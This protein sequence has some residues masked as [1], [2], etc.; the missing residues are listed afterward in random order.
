MQWLWWMDGG[1]AMVGC[2]V[3][4][5]WLVWSWV[6]R[7]TA[8]CVIVVGDVSWKGREDWFDPS[9][10]KTWRFGLLES[11]CATFLLGQR[12]LKAQSVL[13][14]EKRVKKIMMRVLAQNLRKVSTTL[15]FKRGLWNCCCL[16]VFKHGVP[17]GQ[18]SLM[19]NILLWKESTMRNNRTTAAKMNMKLICFNKQIDFF[20]MVVAHW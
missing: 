4:W 10:K 5:W 11:A 8:C 9:R 20:N 18:G 13:P 7:V 14:H 16:T 3:Y 12:S 1:L 17:H 2:L 19:L 6:V 15:H